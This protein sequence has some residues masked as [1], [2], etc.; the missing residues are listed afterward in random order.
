MSTIIK[1]LPIIIKCSNPSNN[2]TES[3]TCMA[4]ESNTK[5]APVHMIWI[6]LNSL[7][8]SKDEFMPSIQLQSTLSDTLNHF[9]ILAGRI[10][11]DTSGNATIHL[12]NEGV[13]FTEAQC[14]DQTLDY[15][16][17]PTM[18]DEEF[19]YDNINVSDL[20]VALAND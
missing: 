5:F 11:E 6:Y 20:D 18:N 19:D 15:F 1:D 8:M 17:K 2:D 13:L 9:P 16:I 12:N 10:T 4:V 3:I 7:K 14:Q